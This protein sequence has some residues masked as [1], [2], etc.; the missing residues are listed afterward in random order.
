MLPRRY[1]PPLEWRQVRIK[2]VLDTTRLLPA[3]LQDQ[4]SQLYAQR[5]SYVPALVIGPSGSLCETHDDTHHS[6]KTISGVTIYTSDF[7]RTVKFVYTDGSRSSEHKGSET[8]G[9]QH[10]MML[11]AGEHITDIFIWRHDW[12]CGLQFVTNFGRCS[13]H[14]GEFSGIPMVARSKGG[15]LV[16]IM[17][18]IQQHEFGRLF[19]KIQGI[20]RHDVVDMV[21]KEEDVFSDYFGSH[22]GRPFNDRVVVRNSNMTISN[23][24]VGCGSFIESLQI[25]YLDTAGQGQREIQTECHGG[26]S[27]KKKKFT[28]EPGENI[29]SVSGKH[30]DQ[31]ITQM[32]FVTDQGR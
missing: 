23:I 7:I 20:W 14:F 19:R 27:D 25:T 32:I 22:G 10:E 13:P 6:A 16:G 26:P 11:T 4:L 21:P 9:A 8:H 30:D 29:T 17:S 2:E 31:R 12:T 15:V 28:L 5:I 24:E 18:L 3:K 1:I